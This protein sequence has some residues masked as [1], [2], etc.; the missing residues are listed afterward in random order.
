MNKAI[1][2]AVVGLALAMAAAAWGLTY[3]QECPNDKP[4]EANALPPELLK[5]IN[6]FPRVYGYFY[7]TGQFYF[8]GDTAALNKFL[9]TLAKLS[10]DK[11][12]LTARLTTE[13][14]EGQK[15]SKS[16][17]TPDAAEKF[18]YNWHLS[19]HT[20]YIMKNNKIVDEE[21]R[22]IAVDICVRGDIDLARLELPAAFKAEVSGRLNDF[23][24][25]H[26]AR[27]ADKDAQ[28]QPTTEKRLTAAGAVFGP[29]ASEA[30]LTRQEMQRR[31]L[32]LDQN[33]SDPNRRPIPDDGDPIRRE[34]RRMITSQPAT[35]R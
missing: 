9:A 20:I 6:D 7:R 13:G 8:K 26:N 15:I 14:G 29:A 16:S 25:G 18:S 34:I 22:D 35:S 31:I 21:F 27:R 17:D 33:K 4:V 32:E 12:T 10:P 11:Y 2:A 5:A 24:G 3:Y 1:K 23:V 19:L 28:T 30:P